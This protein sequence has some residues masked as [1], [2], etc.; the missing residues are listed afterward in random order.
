MNDPD[1][2]RS[3]APLRVSEYAHG[4]MVATLSRDGANGFR[5]ADRRSYDA[6]GLVRAQQTGGDPKL[7]YCANLGHRQDDESGLVYMRARYYEPGSGRFL[8]EDSHAD[9]INWFVYARNNPVGGADRSGHATQQEA[10]IKLDMSVVSAVIALG[11]L[12]YSAFLGS[13]V[14]VKVIAQAGLAMIGAWL[15]IEHCSDPMS[16]MQRLVAGGASL[17]LGS[18]VAGGLAAQAADVAAAGSPAAKAVDVVKTYSAVLTLF[19]AVEN[20]ETQ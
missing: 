4:S 13:T 15:G 19:L 11:W 10:D 8:S 18:I 1:S 9:G 16:L 6:W 5:M 17:Y 12:S 14:E 20:L 7:R 3:C 2:P